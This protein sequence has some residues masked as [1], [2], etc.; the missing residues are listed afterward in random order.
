MKTDFEDP[1]MNKMRLLLLLALTF[2]LTVSIFSQRTFTGRV[3]DI[4]DGKTFVFE[5]D[6]GRLTGTIQY[7]EVPEPEQPLNRIVRDHLQKLVLGKTIVF[8]PN[9]YTPKAAVGKA[10]LDGIDLGQQLVRD[11]AAWHLPIDRSGQEPAESQVYDTNQ[12]MAKAEKRGIWS[13]ANLTPAWEFRA[14][15][16]RSFENSDVANSSNHAVKENKNYNYTKNDQDM[17]IDVGGE[18]LA[19]RNSLGS[20]YYGYDAE[21]KIRNISTP[22]L[23]QTI[24]NGEKR[25]EVELRLVYFQGELRTKVPNT[26]FVLGVLATSKEHNFA[27]ENALKFVADGEELVFENGHRFWREGPASVQELIQYRVNRTALTTIAK[28]RNVVIK[29]GRYHGI[30]SPDVRATLL[31]LIEVSI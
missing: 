29:V 2:A 6:G 11:G 1:K 3:V 22:S 28:A 18:P 13:I 7:I 10:Y 31:K 5:G 25:L 21:K 14:Q 15:K 19:Q 9:G 12:A 26:A 16:D 30:V 23:A 8:L 17:W 20:M 27:T 24:S 4:V